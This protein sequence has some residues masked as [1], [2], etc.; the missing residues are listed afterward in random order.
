MSDSPSH[1]TTGP[2][3]VAIIGGGVTGLAV[4]WRLENPPTD[5][6]PVPAVTVFEAAPRVGGNLRTEQDGEFRVEWGPNGFLSSEPATLELAREAGLEDQLL[7]SDDAARRRFLHVRGKVREIPS[8]PGAFL[9]STL[10]SPAAKLRIA[11]ELLVPRRPHLGEEAEHPEADE[12]V[13]RFGARRLGVEFADTMLDPM[14]RGITGGDCRRVSLAAAFP[15]MVELEKDH[16]GL[17]RALFTLARQ[18]RREGTR[19]EGGTGGPSGVLTSFTGGIQMLPDALA[20]GLRGT[21]R[22]ACP[23]TALEPADGGWSVI[24][25]GQR[26]GPF[27]AVVDAGPAHA[28]AGYHPDAEVRRLLGGIRFN[29][30]TVIAVALRREDVVHPLDGFGMLTPSKERRDLMGVLW[31]SSIWRHRAPAG[32]VLLRCM[33]GDPTWL[34]LPE[35]EVVRRT[36]AE[37]DH[38]YGLR[39]Q[40]LRHWVVRWPQAI[41]EYE[42]GHLARLAAVERALARTPG[43]IITGSSYHGIAVNACMKTSEPVAA[44]VRAIL[45]GEREAAA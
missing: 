37:L 29:P 20:R 12:T 13:W 42:V 30:I 22:T 36:C 38:L 43:L 1:E 40:P 11:G 7:R 15:R 35:A 32:T 26:H 25:G 28:A 45:R 4:A 41:A 5:T 18:R 31:T 44:R 2:P 9:A 39:G 23:V 10:F 24:A 33:A 3:R 8:S 14:V 27:A 21:V 19:R 17:F 6:G 16:G 34:D